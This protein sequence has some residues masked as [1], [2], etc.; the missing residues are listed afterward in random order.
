MAAPNYENFRDNG[1]GRDT[2]FEAP[3]FPLTRVVLEKI[4]PRLRVFFY[5][6]RFI[7]IPKLVINRSDMKTVL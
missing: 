5:V 4:R 7:L 2:K 6:F 1:E 3:P